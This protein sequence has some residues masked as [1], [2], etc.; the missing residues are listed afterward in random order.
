MRP[1]SWRGSR[2][3]LGPLGLLSVLGALLLGGC[4]QHPLST[5]NP[6]GPVARME[7]GLMGEGLWIMVGV[8]AVVATLI[9]IV[10]FRFMQRP[11]EPHST[12]PQIEGDNRLE[13]LWTIV[14]IIILATL[15]IPTIR[16]T[17]VLGAEQPG[18]LQVDVVGHQFWWEFDYPQLGIA[19]ADGMH[20]PVGRKVNIHLTSADV[21]HSFWVPRLAGKQAAIPGHTGFLWLE[22]S[23]AGIYDGECAEFCGTSHSRMHFRV[24][25]QT[26]AAFQAWVQQMTHP[27]DTPTTALA[28]EGQHLFFVTYGCNGC[29]TI[30]GTS[31][32]GTVGPNLTNFHNKGMIVADLFANT[33]QN[34]ATWLQDPP[35][36][37][38]GMVMPDFHLSKGQ[39]AAL[40]AYLEGL[41]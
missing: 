33:P 4:A 12:P 40:V 10:L 37:M 5:L 16:T 39:I 26:P 17:Y 23:Q 14:P 28:R 22:A 18:G 2:S 32:N 13:L 27:V 35:A 29:H 3:R 9:L 20:I 24:V 30:D 36:I 11:G 21:I 38:P 15:L 25:A 41:H 7:L 34:V 31:A 1:G 19:T 6:A 8:F